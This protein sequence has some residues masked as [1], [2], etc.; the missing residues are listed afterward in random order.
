MVEFVNQ[1]LDDDCAICGICMAT[2]EPWEKVMQIALRL[3]E[4][5]PGRGTYNMESIM[6]ELGY[7]YSWDSSDLNAD[8]TGIYVP[9]SMNASWLTRHFLWGRRALVSVPSL[10][11]P[12][13]WHVVYWDG[14]KV[15]DPSNKK[16]Y[17]EPEHL[18][19]RYVLLFN[20]RLAYKPVEEE[21]EAINTEAVNQ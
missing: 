14:Y 7:N 15:Y 9:E 1:Q 16:T 5:R 12:G 19:P 13:G 3:K 4:Y 20:E 6:K 8:I 21:P 17:C 11:E 10:N 18:Q 2:G